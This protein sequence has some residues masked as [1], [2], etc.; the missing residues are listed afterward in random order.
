MPK[1][2]LLEIFTNE[3]SNC[4]YDKDMFK[5]VFGKEESWYEISEEELKNLKESV[6]RHNSKYDTLYYK[7]SHIKAKYNIPDVGKLIIVEDRDVLIPKSLSDYTEFLKNVEKI[8]QQELKAAQDK[9]RK[10][11]EAAEAR[12]KERTLKLFNKLK[13]QVDKAQKI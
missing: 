5:F 10:K 2:K 11:K 8:Y 9:N 3:C 7:G 1:I 4:E 6:A 12:K 13:S